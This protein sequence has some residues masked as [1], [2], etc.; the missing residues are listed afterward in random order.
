[1]LSKP[2][3]IVRLVDNEA[4]SKFFKSYRVTSILSVDAV[5]GVI[6]II[7]VYAF[8]LMFNANQILV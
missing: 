1:M 7:N 2:S 3:F 8:L 4:K 5:N 6:H